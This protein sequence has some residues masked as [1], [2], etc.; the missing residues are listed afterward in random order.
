MN[1]LDREKE[2]LTEFRKMQPYEKGY[3]I[4]RSI[5]KLSSLDSSVLPAGLEKLT[6]VQRADYVRYVSLLLAIEEF[7]RELKELEK[8]GDM[9]LAKLRDKRLLYLA[10]QEK[11]RRGK[12]PKKRQKLEKV[13]GEILRLREG[14]FRVRDIKKIIWKTHRISVSKSYLSS[15]LK[16]WESG[17]TTV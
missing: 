3:V 4:R 12:K 8:E 9:R 5:E 17:K 6:D 1:I 13:K 15:I 11:S 16:E 10:E 2:L 14:G 7:V